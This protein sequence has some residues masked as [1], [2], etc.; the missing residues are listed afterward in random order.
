MARDRVAGEGE[1]ERGMRQDVGIRSVDGV[2]R[3]GFASILT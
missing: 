2:G 3:G 1:M